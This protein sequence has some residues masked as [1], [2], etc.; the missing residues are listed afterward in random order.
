LTTVVSIS[1]TTE[2]AKR[3]PGSER[4]ERKG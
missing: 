1:V 4:L 2:K 3:L